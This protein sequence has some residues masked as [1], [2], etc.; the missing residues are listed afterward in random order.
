MRVYDDDYW[1]TRY[2]E[3][4][5]ENWFEWDNP[6]R[7]SDDDKKAFHDYFVSGDWEKNNSWLFH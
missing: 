5:D 7:F 4:Q 3:L 1:D 6:D 2:Q